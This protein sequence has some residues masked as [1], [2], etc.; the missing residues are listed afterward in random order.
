MF[1]E[2]LQIFNMGSAIAVIATPN[3]L[4]RQYESGK[5]T[6]TLSVSSS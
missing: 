4:Y 3:E 6:R 5:P 2:R 1:E